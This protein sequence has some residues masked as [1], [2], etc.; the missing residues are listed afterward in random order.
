MVHAKSGNCYTVPVV[1]KL[2]VLTECLR[3]EGERERE[4]RGSGSLPSQPVCP[5]GNAFAGRR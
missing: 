4:I 2:T 3:G 5:G 1:A